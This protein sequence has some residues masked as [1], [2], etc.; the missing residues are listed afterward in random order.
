MKKGSVIIVAI[1]AILVL[2]FIAYVNLI[3]S[4][5][6]TDQKISPLTAQVENEKTIEINNFAYSP[7]SINIKT[8]DSVMWT[9]NDQAAHTITSDSGTELNSQT[10]STSQTY[11][12]TFTETGTYNYHCSLH[13]GM[14]A[15]IIV[16]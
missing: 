2:F 10:L 14:K 4:P 6:E 7:S 16:S 9:N 15:K 1:L 11:S 8:G 13:P 3:K 12:N 5:N